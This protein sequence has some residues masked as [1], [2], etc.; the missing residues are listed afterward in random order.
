[1]SS[2]PWISLGHELIHAIHEAEG[3]WDKHREV[4]NKKWDD[5]E[6]KVTISGY[7]DL[8]CYHRW[9]ENRLRSAFGEP[10]RIDHQ[11][12]R[13][14]LS[15]NQ[16]LYSLVCHGVD[17]DLEDILIQHP[18]AIE[19]TLNIE[20]EQLTLLQIAVLQGKTKVAKLLS[21]HGADL[22]VPTS[23]NASLLDLAQRNSSQ[24]KMSMVNWLKKPVAR[25]N[26]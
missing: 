8:S 5:L 24:M 23:Q 14:N 12:M 11:G 6:E 15:F 13:S 16:H 7:D 19:L 20:N 18:S 21:K 26:I 9:N 25:V 1:M 2:K 22:G 3:T 17:G 4:K 10:N